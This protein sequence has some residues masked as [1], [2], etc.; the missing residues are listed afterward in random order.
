MLAAILDRKVAGLF[1]NGLTDRE[2]AVYNE[3]RWAE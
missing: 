2:L 1:W 3:T